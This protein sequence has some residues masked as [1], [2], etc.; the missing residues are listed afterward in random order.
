MHWWL[1][2]IPKACRHFHVPKIDF[3][4]YTYASELDWGATD[5]CFSIG[6]GWDVNEQI[7]IKFLEQK[8]VFLALNRYCESWNGSRNVRINSED[9][10][11]MAYLNNMGESVCKVQYI[12]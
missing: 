1:Q 5:G 6:G 9:T 7:H 8:A 2:H 4:I 10:T 3:K 11:A 12:I